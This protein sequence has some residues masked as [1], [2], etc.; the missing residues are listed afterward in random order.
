MA[1][2]TAQDVEK[3]FAELEAQLAQCGPG[4][5]DIMKI[6]GQS[7]SAIQPASDYFSIMNPAPI[8]ST[9]NTSG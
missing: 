6:Y 7:E 1:N 8:V 5:I 4:I 9:S 3:E 2:D